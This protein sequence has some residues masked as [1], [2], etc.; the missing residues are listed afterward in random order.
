[1]YFAIP[2]PG[3]ENLLSAE[4][5]LVNQLVKKI[6]SLEKKYFFYLVAKIR[7]ILDQ[8]VAYGIH[9]NVI[10]SFLIRRKRVLL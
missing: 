9:Y 4:N 10:P 1:M 7:L 3:D 8:W 6:I 5:F 2:V